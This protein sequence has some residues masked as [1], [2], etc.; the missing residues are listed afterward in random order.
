M[1]LHTYNIYC[2]HINII[3]PYNETPDQAQRCVT[4]TVTYVS[5]SQRLINLGSYNLYHF[6][7]HTIDRNTSNLK[8]VI[9][10]FFCCQTY[11]VSGDFRSGGEEIE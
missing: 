3:D 2:F 7:I 4:L 9:L 5:R 1:Y 6:C 10:S 11:D 8:M